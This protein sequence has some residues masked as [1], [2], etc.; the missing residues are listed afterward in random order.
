[1]IMTL[2]EQKDMGMKNRLSRF[3]YRLI[4]DKDRNPEQ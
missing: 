1:M 3:L 4:K 2:S